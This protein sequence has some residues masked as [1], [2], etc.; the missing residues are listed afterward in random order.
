MPADK[1]AINLQH[2]NRER[3][4]PYNLRIED[5]S[6][7]MQDVYDFFYDVNERLQNRGLKRLDDMLR[8]A[9]MSGLIS[10]ML[11]A[12]LAQHARS[13]T[14]NQ[15]H[16]GHPDLIEAGRYPNDSVASGTMGVE[17]KTTRNSRASVDMHGARDQW[18]CVF[19]YEVDN[20]TE[21]AVDRRPMRFTQVYLQEVKINDFRRNER[22]ELGTRTAS[23]DREGITKLRKGWVYLVPSAR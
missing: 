6:I 7:A 15:Y 3:S 2:F 4:L 23:L 5:Y 18:L 10:D 22:G 14:D 9:A 17:I 19:V 13:L 8:P 11:T 1:P 16:N 12:S 21:P 20:E